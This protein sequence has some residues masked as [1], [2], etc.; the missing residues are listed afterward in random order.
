MY[1]HICVNFTGNKVHSEL[2]AGIARQTHRQVYVFVPCKS[3]SLFGRND[4][5]LPNVTVQYFYVPP[6]LRY[7]QLIKAAYSTA[8]ILR[9]AKQHNINLKQS[10]IVAHTFWSDGALAYLL[11]KI[12][13]CG[14][15]ATIRSTDIHVFFK[16]GFHL[17]PIMRAIA[18]AA[19]CIISPNVAYIKHVSKLPW[20]NIPHDKLRF[21][22]N[23][24]SDWWLDS[25]SARNSTHERDR[26]QLCFVGAF[27]RNKNIRAVIEA[28]ALVRDRGFPIRL[29]CAGGNLLQLKRATGLLSIPSWVEVLGEIHDRPT[30]ANLYRRSQALILPSYRETFGMVYL[31]ALSQGCAIIFSKGQGVD[32]LFFEPYFQYSVDPSDVHSIAAAILSAINTEFSL[33][34]EESERLLRPFSIDSI[35]KNYAKLETL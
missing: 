35:L 32:G 15:V 11:D 34:P 23:P 21:I 8:R 18:A 20:L 13:N 16:Y 19:A 3:R 5:Q 9:L 2:I 10:R 31:E 27:S 12:Y 24:I 17:R 28:C 25:I 33:A 4:P 30:L 22:P 6:F 29:S 7:F 1:T 26:L 14:F